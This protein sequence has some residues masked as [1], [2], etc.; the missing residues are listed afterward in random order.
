MRYKITVCSNWAW[1][2]SSFLLPWNLVTHFGRFCDQKSSYLDAYEVNLCHSCIHFL[3][4]H[5]NYGTIEKGREYIM[6][7]MRLPWSQAAYWTIFKEQDLLQKPNL[8]NWFFTPLCQIFAMVSY[9]NVSCSYKYFFGSLNEK[10]VSSN[11]C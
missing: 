7:D 2:R 5:P 8:H 6:L 10:H 11:P 3:T 1:H 4:C 9:F